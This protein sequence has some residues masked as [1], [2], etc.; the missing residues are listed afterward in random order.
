VK[1]N[2]KVDLFMPKWGERPRVFDHKTCGD[3]RWALT[4]DRL[5]GDIQGSLYGGWAL[6]KTFAEQVDLQWNYVVTK[7]AVKTLPVVTSVRGRDIQERLGRTLETAR[8]MQVVMESGARA[9]QVQ[10]DPRGCSAFGGCPHQATCN[11]NAQE[12]VTSIAAQAA[13]A[14]TKGSN[15]GSTEDFLAS[16]AQGKTNGQQGMQIVSQAT[17]PVVQAVNPTPLTQYAS[18]QA[19]SQTP[20]DF[21]AQPAAAA[22]QPAQAPLVPQVTQ[23]P[24]QAPLAQQPAQ[25]PLIPQPVQA[26]STVLAQVAPQ[27]EAPKAGPGRPA[28]VKAAD[29]PWVYFASAALGELVA[30]KAVP[31]QAAPVAAQYADHLVQE[32]QR[33]K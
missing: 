26:T 32:Y 2:L 27:P 20:L 28:K 22:P 12:R 6:H 30:M 21:T 11:L 31:E 16:L 8:R 25:V 10:Y 5:P 17:P 19:P 9:M 1:F 15:M 4:P 7:G 18:T 33:R 24:A 29:D 13:A 14:T 23:Q 3:F